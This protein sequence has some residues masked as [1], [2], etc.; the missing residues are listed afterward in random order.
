MRSQN[1]GPGRLLTYINNDIEPT[2]NILRSHYK[3]DSTFKA[4]LNILAVITSHLTT[5]N[6]SVYQILTKTNIFINKTVEKKR[7]DNIISDENKN[8]I[9]DLDES[10]ILK[11]IQ[12]LD[13]IKERL[14]FGLYTLQPARRLEYRNVILTTETDAQ[15]LNN[16][17][18]N[19]LIISTTPKQL[20]FNNYKTYKTYGQQIIN[21]E[22]EYLNNMIDEYIKTYDLKPKDYLFYVDTRK[23]RKPAENAFSETISNIFKNVYGVPICNKYIR[24]SWSIYIHDLKISANKKEVLINMMAHSYSESQQKYYKLV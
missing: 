15:K 21:I 17:K 13:D 8:K 12:K 23:Y 22:N 10:K 18:T 19:Y 16:N 3:N 2:I 6:K 7:K 9:I 4:Y 1:I 14:I 20:I 5:L 24:V 11:N